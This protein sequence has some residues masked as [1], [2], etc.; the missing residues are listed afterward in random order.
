MNNQTCMDIFNNRYNTDIDTS[1]QLCAGA[2]E[3]KDSCSG[4]S[5]GPLAYK[6][7]TDDPYYQVGIGYVGRRKGS[8][9]NFS[10]SFCDLVWHYAQCSTL[11]VVH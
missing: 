9:G 2:E 6:Q 8:L 10:S 7:S 1:I 5:G 4:D 11:C 3:S